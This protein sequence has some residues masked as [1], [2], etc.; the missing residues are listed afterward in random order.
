MTAKIS[1]WSAIIGIVVIISYAILGGMTYPAYDHAAQYLS[2]LG[3]I[4]A[5]H[6]E[7]ISWG[8][9]FLFGVLIILFAI[10]AWLSLPKST[11]MTVGFI[12]IAYYAVGSMQAAFFP[13]DIG[14]RPEDPSFS[15]IMHN[16][17]GGTS[18]LA[19]LIGLIILGKIARK[20]QNAS[21]LSWFGIIG[22]V[23]GIIAFGFLDPS[24]AYVGI[25]QRVLETCMNF[26]ILLC[27]F[28]IRKQ[29][30]DV[31]LP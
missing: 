25:A 12:A 1:F 4:D 17:I 31:T 24:F 22:G 5:P 27:A 21:A 29:S 28:Y 9:F 10:T 13:C 30:S 7:L 23:I 8:G 11:L 26:W 18:Y 2:E 15:Q 16:V 19:G 20:W 14:C 6:R 3:A